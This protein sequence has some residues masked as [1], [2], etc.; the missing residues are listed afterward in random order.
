MVQGRTWVWLGTGGSLLFLIGGLANVVKVFK[1]QQMGDGLRLE[2]L[3]GGAQER[4]VRG[5]EG[6]VPLIVEDHRR[7]SS[8]RPSARYDN[9]YHTHHVEPNPNV[10]AEPAPTPCKDVLVSQTS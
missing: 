10:A 4:L 7:R 5:R 2:K 6:H 9:N 1:M 8:Q 3:R